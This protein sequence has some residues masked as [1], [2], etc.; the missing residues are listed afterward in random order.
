[1]KKNK[2]LCSE[3]AIVLAIF[4]FFLIKLFFLKVSSLVG[5]PANQQLLAL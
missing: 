5:V 2:I 4:S 1:V 3:K